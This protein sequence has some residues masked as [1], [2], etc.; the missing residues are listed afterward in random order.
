[1]AKNRTAFANDTKLIA[2]RAYTVEGHELKRGDEVPAD[3]E[4]ERRQKLWL[5]DYADYEA[6]FKPTPQQAQGAEASDSRGGATDASDSDNEQETEDEDGWKAEVDGVRVDGPNGSWFT[7]VDLA[8]G[9]EE[10]K[11]QGVD[12]AKTLAAELRLANRN[13]DNGGAGEG[14]DSED[15]DAE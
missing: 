7:I 10:H 11:E 13:A 14:G 9:G 5:M 3:V 12:D 4:L 6:D 2:T 1:M 8:N 15:D